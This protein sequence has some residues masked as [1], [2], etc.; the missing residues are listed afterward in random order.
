MKIY[1]A[2]LAGK[3]LVPFN[4]AS[5]RTAG[6]Y[7]YAYPPDIPLIVPGEKITGEDI[8]KINKMIKDGLTI[9]GIE[10]GKFRVLEQE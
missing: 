4:E 1:E 10:N 7:I 5:G 8:E 9:I 2:M 6:D 3:T